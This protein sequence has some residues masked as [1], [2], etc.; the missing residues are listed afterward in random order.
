[1]RT[2]TPANQADGA[3]RTD[4][5]PRAGMSGL[6]AA[7]PPRWAASLPMAARSKRERPSIGWHIW[8][9]A[10]DRWPTLKG[11]WTNPPAGSSPALRK[12]LVAGWPLDYR[13]TNIDC[14]RLFPKVEELQ[15]H[16]YELLWP[17]SPPVG[18]NRSILPGASAE[19]R[20]ELHFAWPLR[21]SG[22]G[23]YRQPEARVEFAPGGKTR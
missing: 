15:V 12:L 4:V 9:L 3:D 11:D 13:G 6:P 21:V 16:S 14:L 22:R 18:G 5:V 7:H 2:P 17:T 10:R 19:R 20:F 1:M 23:S 8:P